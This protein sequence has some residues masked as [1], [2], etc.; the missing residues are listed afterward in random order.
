MRRALDQTAAAVRP[1]IT[2]QELD[3]IGAKVSAEHG[4]ESLPPK[5]YGF[6]GA[7]CI[8]VN[9]E[10]IHGIPGERAIRSGDL[11]KL[12]LV[13]VKEGFYGDAAV[14]IRA[15]EVSL[16][17]LWL[18]VPPALSIKRCDRRARATGCTRSAGWWSGNQALRLSSAARSLR[19]WR[20]TDNP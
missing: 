4:A 16:P 7:L 19:S 5:V 8:S 18:V 1:G 12:D 3:A 9:E 2:T 17:T 11:V 6:P 10:A 20:W 14:T 15:G 13:V